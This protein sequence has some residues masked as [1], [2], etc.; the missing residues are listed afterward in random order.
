M[1]K[2]EPKTASNSDIPT[3]VQHQDNLLSLLLQITPK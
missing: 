2:E 1:L 3:L